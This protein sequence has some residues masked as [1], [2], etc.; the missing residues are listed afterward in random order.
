[1]VERVSHFSDEWP[2]WD[3][4]TEG[5]PTARH[6]GAEEH[7][8]T[9][10]GDTIVNIARSIFVAAA[11]ASLAATATAKPFI[12]LWVF[13]DST[14]DTGWYRVPKFR[15][16][17]PCLSGDAAFDAFLAPTSR[18]GRTGAEKWGIG[19]PT[20]S[21]GLMSVEVLADILGV[22]AFPQN[23]LGTN[24][25][26]SGARNEQ[27][28]TVGSGFFPNAIP[29]QQQI[30]N[31]LKIIHPTGLALYVVS[32]GGNDVAAALN[33]YSGCTTPAQMDVQNAAMSLADKIS[34]LQQ[35]NA[36]YII[37]ANLPESFGNA[38]QMA[39]RQTYN[40]ALMAALNS[41]GVSYAWG[42][43][44]GVRTKIQGSSSSFG[45]SILY[46]SNP[47]CSVP[48]VS[49]NITTAWALVCSPTS[50]AS[51]PTNAAISEFADDE[52]WATGGQRVL[53]S[54]YFCLAKNT[55]TTVFNARPS[56]KLP[57]ITCNT[58]D[59]SWY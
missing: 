20:S 38:D 50:P 45:I 5:E 37:V 26:T 43:V 59:P 31:Y 15:S 54:Y 40:T 25:A 33:T 11:L 21:P 46:N 10:H 1:M 14:V 39:C 48:A 16:N 53:G 23:Q 44:N 51:T 19:K 3:N 52:H 4:A 17:P 47:A 36:R 42:D 34:S 32:S 57:P 9:E 6:R 58:F 56:P 35:H 28:N 29:T 22:A 8:A 7:F 49:T 13:G 12:N 24:Y 55:W 41:L 30:E 2:L 18:H 27:I